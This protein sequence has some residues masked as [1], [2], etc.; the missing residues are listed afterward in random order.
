MEPERFSIDANVS[1]AASPPLAVPVARL[2]VTPKSDAPYKTFAELID[3]ARKNPGRVRIGPYRVG[4]Q[5]H[6]EI[7]VALVKYWPHRF[8]CVEHN[9]IHVHNLLMIGRGV[10]P[11]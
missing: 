5:I 10:T 11:K 4:T 2:T 8:D 3:Y 6:P 1:P 9:L 7:M